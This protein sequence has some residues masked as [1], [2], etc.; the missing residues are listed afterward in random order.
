VRQI[1]SENP[2][3]TKKQYVKE[4]NSRGDVLPASSQPG[5]TFFVMIS[6]GERLNENA[7]DSTVGLKRM[8]A[9]TGLN[10]ERNCHEQRDQNDYRTML[11]PRIG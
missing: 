4:T 11:S 10:W 5:V 1:R 9:E 8:N 3:Q 2:K 7:S 6:D